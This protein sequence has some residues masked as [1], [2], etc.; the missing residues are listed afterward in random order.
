MINDEFGKALRGKE[1]TEEETAEQ[2][3][4]I[5]ALREF[6]RP[7]KR[8]VAA[9]IREYRATQ[10]AQEWPVT[11]GAIM[12]TEIVALVVALK[13]DLLIEGMAKALLD[14]GI[15]KGLADDTNS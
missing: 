14:E 7:F 12:L 10:T 2:E 5:T 13:K 8:A 1:L 3:R 9:G 4:A 11:A 6:M 15:A